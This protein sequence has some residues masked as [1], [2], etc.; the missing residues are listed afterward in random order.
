MAKQVHASLRLCIPQ[1]DRVAG[2]ALI[3][4]RCSTRHEFPEIG[5]R[6][7]GKPHNRPWC[8]EEV[9]EG[10]SSPLVNCDTGASIDASQFDWTLGLELH[11]ERCEWRAVLAASPV[12]IFISGAPYGLP[13]LVEVSQLP[14]ST[15]FHLAVIEGRG[16]HM[17]GN[18]STL[19]SGLQRTSTP[20]WAS[21]KVA[22]VQYCSSS[23]R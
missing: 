7:S 2:T 19:L 21:S 11:D 17:S 1:I 16:C 5:F 13:G 6:L 22:P 15:P 20:A 8:C 10:W 9:L 23:Q 12:H 18:G 14:R 4:L 3:V